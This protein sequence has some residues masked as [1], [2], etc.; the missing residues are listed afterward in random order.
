MEGLEAKRENSSAWEQG[1]PKD[2]RVSSLFSN[3]SIRGYKISLQ[4]LL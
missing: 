1:V 4:V 3:M 2:E